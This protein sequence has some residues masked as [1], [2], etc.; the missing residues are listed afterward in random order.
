ML[1]LNRVCDSE[2][3]RPGHGMVMDDDTSC[4][5]NRCSNYPKRDGNRQTETG[6][7]SFLLANSHKLIRRWP[8]YTGYSFH[9]AFLLRVRYL[10]ES[11]T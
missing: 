6:R 7:S 8:L 10:S 3:D 1:S 4:T 5:Q 9:S 11:D 2:F